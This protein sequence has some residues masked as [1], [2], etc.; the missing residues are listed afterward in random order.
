VP[1]EDPTLIGEYVY[2]YSR[3]LQ[4]RLRAGAVEASESGRVVG[5]TSH[6]HAMWARERA[7][8]GEDPRYLKVVSTAK[9]FSECPRLPAAP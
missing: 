2:H 3:A 1:G 9:H 7:Q 4:V 6:G 8:E 5:R